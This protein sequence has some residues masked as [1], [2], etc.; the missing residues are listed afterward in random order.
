MSMFPWPFD[1]E[2]TID[3]G[4]STEKAIQ[5]FGDAGID[6]QWMNRENIDFNA[7]LLKIDSKTI[8]TSCH[9]SFRETIEDGIQARRIL[10][11]P[12]SETVTGSTEPHLTTIRRSENSVESEPSILGLDPRECNM[13]VK[14]LQRIVN[15]HRY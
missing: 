3:E 1:F 5:L 13:K 4:P 15:I 9:F 11:T 12:S 8:H 14:R 6:L 7:Y 10:E 2:I